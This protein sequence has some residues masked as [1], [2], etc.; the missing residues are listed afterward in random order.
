MRSNQTNALG[1]R[2]VATT[3]VTVSADASGGEFPPGLPEPGWP[4][5][6]NPG[7]LTMCSLSDLRHH[8]GYVR[9]GLTVPASRLSALAEQG[10]AAFRE[11]LTITQERVVIDGYARWELARLEGR[12]ELPCIEYDLPEEAAIRWLLQKHRR[13]CGMN[14]F[15]RILLAGELE[16][17]L[18]VKALSNQRI[19]GRMKGSSNLTEDLAVDVRKEVAAAAGVSVGNVT[20]VRQLMGVVHREV[21]EA[22]RDGEVSIHRAWKWSRETLDQQIE[23]LRAYRAKRGVNKSIRDLISRH[24]Q[25]QSPTAPSLTNLARRLAELEPD[26]SKS[27]TVLVIRPPGK[28]V[29]VTEEL[30]QFLRSCQSAICTTNNR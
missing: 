14:D 2:N 20:K 6:N 27:I 1:G 18:K 4:H 24:K 28:M 23:E 22:L 15:C 5:G 19:G 9:L 30:V 25:R 29:L 11:P 16:P 17:Y 12:L 10:E 8:P 7:Q 26:E 3:A 13:S 21:L